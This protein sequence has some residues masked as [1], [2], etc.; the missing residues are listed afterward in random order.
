V[1]AVADGHVIV[2]VGNDGQFRRLLALLG[3]AG[4]PLYASN[5]DRVRNRAALDAFLSPVIARRHRDELLAALAAANVPGGPINDLAQV[6]ADPQVVAR[7]MRIDPGGMPGIASP[8]VL[9][10][11]RQAAAAP[12]PGLA[13]DP[14]A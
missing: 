14:D 4:D 7:G 3:L 12:S 5:A 13:G 10:G 2:A 11:R 9:D 6:F 1:F 8:I